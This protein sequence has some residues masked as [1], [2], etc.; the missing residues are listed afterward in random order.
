[1]QYINDI[2][3]PYYYILTLICSLVCCSLLFIGLLW[4]FV[5]M[6][7]KRN[8]S[9]KKPAIKPL[10]IFRDI[11]T[12]KEEYLS[13]LAGL[14]KQVAEGKISNRQIFKK[15]SQ[16]L[17]G[18]IGEAKKILTLPKTKTELEP[19]KMDY[20]NGMIDSCYKVEFSK[21]PP[22]VDPME[23]ISSIKKYIKKWN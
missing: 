12:I 7:I 21:D 1:M 16:I 20:L 8:K 6:L 18:F 22:K 23:F 19:L 10:P 9:K 2:K 11:N 5:V 17:R 14:E 3:L 13:A 15:I 4:G